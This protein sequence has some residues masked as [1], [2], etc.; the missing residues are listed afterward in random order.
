MKSPKTREGPG[1]CFYKYK[2]KGVHVWH[3]NFPAVHPGL[4][5]ESLKKK[6]SG[7]RGTGGLYINDFVPCTF[8]Q[9]YT[10]HM[11]WWH[12]VISKLEIHNLRM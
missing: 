5:G 11:V 12:T 10:V 6:V 9:C 4:V 8:F 3:T 2:E 7:G 1:D